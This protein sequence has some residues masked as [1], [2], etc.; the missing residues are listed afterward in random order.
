M[1][2]DYKHDKHIKFSY[3]S[4]LIY[5]FLL[6]NKLAHCAII[7]WNELRNFSVNSELP[8][9]WSTSCKKYFKDF[10]LIVFSI[11]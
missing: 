7:D 9:A 11:H 4:F 10:N 2:L 1:N 3:I 6:I 8:T 5:I